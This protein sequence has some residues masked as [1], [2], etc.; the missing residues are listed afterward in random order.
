MVGLGHGAN[1]VNRGAQV[2][3]VDITC[4]PLASR[5]FRA[6]QGQVHGRAGAVGRR[7]GRI[8]A[9][10]G[11]EATHLRPDRRQGRRGPLGIHPLQAALL[12][13]RLGHHEALHR[14]GPPGI[15]NQQ[16]AAGPQGG[17]VAFSRQQLLHHAGAQAEGI[18]LGPVGGTQGEVGVGL[19]PQQSRG[20]RLQRLARFQDRDGA[21][22][23]QGWGFRRHGWGEGCSTRWRRPFKPPPKGGPERALGRALPSQRSDRART[24]RGRSSGPN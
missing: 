19:Q 15:K 9:G 12:A 24:P 17:Q 23:A 4:L 8:L 22:G 11:P 10:G 2:E 18:G 13:N 6:R 21:P 5:V 14:Q 7:C 16:P 20:D 3:L 1:R